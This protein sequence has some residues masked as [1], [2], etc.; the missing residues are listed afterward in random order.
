MAPDTRSSGREPFP[1]PAR[2][3]LRPPVV[4]EFVL[5]VT[6]LVGALWWRWDIY[7]M[8][9]L[10]LLAIAVSGA[11][12]GLRTLVLSC[13]ALLYFNPATRKPVL[14]PLPG[15]A[16]SVHRPHHSRRRRSGA[17]VRRPDH[18]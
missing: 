11:W 6:P 7:L 1:I 16:L 17:D 14:G 3:F 4:V 18:R 9:M 15:R 2:A 10:H 12:L 8:L 13:K 5:G